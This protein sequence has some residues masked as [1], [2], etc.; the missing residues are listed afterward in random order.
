MKLEVNL[1]S[2]MKLLILLALVTVSYAQ[3]TRVNCKTR[4]K[5][6]LFIYLVILKVKLDV[7]YGALCPD[8]FAFMTQLNAIYGNF[9]RNLDITFVPFGKSSVRIS[10]STF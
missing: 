6:N 2:N 4:N 10:S 5:F 1:Q 8:T 7:Y 9:S 3:T